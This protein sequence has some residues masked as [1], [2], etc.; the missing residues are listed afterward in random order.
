MHAEH[1]A[2]DIES[3]AAPPRAHHIASRPNGAVNPHLAN[4]RDIAQPLTKAVLNEKFRMESPRKPS[5]PPTPPAAAAATARD[6]MLHLP[7]ALAC[8]LYRHVRR[9]APDIQVNLLGRL[10][11]L[12]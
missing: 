6:P 1:H 5:S 4:K 8:L 7:I 10:L 2:D 12:P 9:V 11:P 3:A